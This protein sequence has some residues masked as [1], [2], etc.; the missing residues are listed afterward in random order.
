V[1]KRLVLGT[2]LA[3]TALAMVASC[4][5]IQEQSECAT[6]HAN[7]MVVAVASQQCFNSP[8]CLLSQ[9]DYI[10]LNVA[11]AKVTVLCAKMIPIA[12]E[13][14]LQETLPTEKDKWTLPNASPP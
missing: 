14:V 8:K 13:P 12:T 4:A 10:N 11:K 3:A 1:K 9:E 2:F 5:S 7:Y 6:A